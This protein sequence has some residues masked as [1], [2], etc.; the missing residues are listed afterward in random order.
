MIT[1]SKEWKQAL[2][3][4]SARFGRIV[5]LGTLERNETAFIQTV[6]S[7]FNS[8]RACV[9]CATAGFVD[10]LPQ[11]DK[12]IVTGFGKD[13]RNACVTDALVATCK[14]IG[15][16]CTTQKLTLMVA[17]V[18][19]LFFDPTKEKIVAAAAK[20]RDRLRT[21]SELDVIRDLSSL[22]T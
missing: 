22:V 3:L 16:P 17:F 18:S 8:D 15:I 21:A 2:R 11:C 12:C 1:V 9:L 7:M 19:V 13:M 4:A 5:E 20:L 10:E 6:Q 14:R